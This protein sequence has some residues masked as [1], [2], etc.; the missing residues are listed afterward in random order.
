MELEKYK[1]CPVCGEHNPPFLLEC[2]KCEADL[3]GIK[4]A[5]S[6]SF[7]AENVEVASA[8]DVGSPVASALIRICECGA[9]NPPQARICASC[10]EDISDIQPSSA[11]S[12]PKSC[13]LLSLNGDF[14]FS[15]SKPVCIIGRENEMN[16]YLSNK[17][18]VS[19]RHAKITMVGEEVFI[20][21]LSGTN[22]TYINNKLLSNDAPAL[23]TNGDEIGL[24]GKMI[25]DKRQDQA[26]YFIFKLQS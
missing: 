3:T 25:N 21:N 22:R 12:A 18:Y 13:A 2:R 11:Q 4:V 17:S 26:A 24:G 7:Q 14:M 19:R 6:T 10:G 15:I 5:D 16:D 23:L 20:E 8:P 9:H 1:I